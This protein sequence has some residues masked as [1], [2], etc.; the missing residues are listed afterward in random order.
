MKHKYAA[1]FVL[2]T[3]LISSLFSSCSKSGSNPAPKIVPIITEP[4]LV[5][6]IYATGFKN[7]QGLAIDGSG[8]LYVG[9]MYNNLV[10][11]VSPTGVV[12]TIA[13]NGSQGLANGTG[14]AAVFASPYGI[15]VDAS[16]TIYV[17]DRGNS[18]IRQIS[19]GQVVTTLAGGYSG[20]SNGFATNGTGTGSS[21]YGPTG[22][23][24]DASGN[25]YVSDTENNLIRKISP[26]AIV[27]TFAGSYGNF[28]SVNGTGT[29]ATFYAPAGLAVDAYGNVYVADAANMLIRKISPSGIVTTLAGSGARGAA[30]GAADKASFNAPAGVAV[31][32]LGNVY[33]ADTGNNMIRKIN[34]SGTVS[35]YADGG[36]FNAPSG[37]AVDASGNVYV[38]DSNNN[39]IRKI[40][41]Q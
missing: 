26:G 41:K 10:R 25:L 3:F 38:A 39:V 15:A 8:N 9:D 34:T 35:T 2:T 24:I 22:L 1:I 4:A 18:L 29:A 40:I 33:V 19:P 7:P 14:T 11:K 16:N 31:D 27:T 23:A 36:Y 12:S 28:G 37:I 17:T 30:N 21:F 5:V 20:Y 32:A 13:G 6:N